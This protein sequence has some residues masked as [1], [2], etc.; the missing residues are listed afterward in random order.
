MVCTQVH[1]DLIIYFTHILYINPKL[2]VLLLCQLVGSVQTVRGWDWYWVTPGHW[3]R[4]AGPGLQGAMRTDFHQSRRP[5]LC[6]ALAVGK[7]AAT[8]K[9]GIGED[10]RS[11]ARYWQHAT[12]QRGSV[13][14][15][16][17]LIPSCQKSRSKLERFLFLISLINVN[18]TLKLFHYADAQFPKV[19]IRMYGFMYS[20]LFCLYRQQMVWNMFSFLFVLHT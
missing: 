14:F 11:I 17:W 1:T 3:H 9:L 2:Y 8:G 15:K 5:G 4:E 10:R 6:R 7:L 16:S 18:F 12:R 13:K 20:L 19:K